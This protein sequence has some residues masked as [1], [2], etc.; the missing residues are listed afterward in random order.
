[1]GAKDRE[2][3]W[4]V[5]LPAALP[6]VMTGVQVA[7]PVALIVAI[8]TEMAMGGFGIGGV[9]MQASRFADS[10]GVFAGIVE[11]AIVGYCLVQALAFVRRR[12]LRWHQEAHAPST[13]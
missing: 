5:L 13:V 3:V 7:L 12:L 4:Q 1:M 10:R 8:F 6:Q 2:L 9:M 11:I